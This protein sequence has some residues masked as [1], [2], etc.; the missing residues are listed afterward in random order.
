MPATRGTGKQ[1]CC[2]YTRLVTRPVIGTE[3]DRCSKGDE[4]WTLRQ[5]QPGAAG[6][7]T[8][9]RQELAGDRQ[10]ATAVA[11]IRAEPVCK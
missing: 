10:V 3:S 5:R 8:L 9:Q 4:P 1:A 7:R 11:S 2:G 6:Q